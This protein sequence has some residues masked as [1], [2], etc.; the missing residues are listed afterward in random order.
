MKGTFPEG[1]IMRHCG[2]ARKKKYIEI[3]RRERCK[4]LNI[5]IKIIAHT[6]FY[7]RNLSI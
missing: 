3:I 1:W 7:R 5:I 4:W 6:K 2:E